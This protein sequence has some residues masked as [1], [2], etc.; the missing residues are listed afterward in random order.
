MF[1]GNKLEVLQKLEL[2][3]LYQIDLLCKKHGLKYFLVGGTLLGAARHGGFIPWDD[4]IDIGMLRDDYDRFIEIA[5]KELECP[6]KVNTYKNN[7]EH[8]YYFIHVV[9]TRYSVKRLGS[10]DQRVENVWVDI[11]P[12]DGM[13]NNKVA[14]YAYYYTLQVYNFLFHIGYFEK[15]NLARPGRPLYQKLLLSVLKKIYRYINIDGSSWRRKFD[16]LLHTQCLEKSNYI[17]SPAGM[18]GTKEIFEKE[19]F[20][21]M[22]KLEFEG[23]VCYVP[24]NYSRYLTKL[25]GDWM[26]PPK[27]K[28][29]HPMEILFSDK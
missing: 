13:P 3:I 11:Y 17:F 6:Y 1:E 4:D 21:P 27:N 15:I 20:I 2:D 29:V 14:R 10:L 5:Q 18:G 24:N 28:E 9:N 22:S 19:D 7:A 8:H 26:S 23:K 12:Y 16:N 25:Y